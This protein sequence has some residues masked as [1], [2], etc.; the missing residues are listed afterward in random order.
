[1]SA[2]QANDVVQI[3]PQT[4]HT[5]DVDSVAYSPDGQRIV[6]GSDDGSIKVWET[7]NKQLVVTLLGFKDGEWIIYT[8]DNY[9]VASPNGDQ[10]VTFR[11]NNDSYGV[12]QYAAL[13]ERP[14]I[15][16]AALQGQDTQSLI[17]QTQQETGTEQLSISELIP[18]VVMIQY[19]RGYDDRFLE[20]ESQTLS[21]SIVKVFAKARDDKYGINRVEV[22]HNGNIVKT[23]VGSGKKSLDIVVPIYLSE[24]QI[25]NRIEL[26]AHSVK[27]VISNPDKI[28]LTYNEAM[29]KG[30]PLPK[31]GNHFFG[32]ERSW[33]VVIGIDQYPE[34]SGYGPLP[35]AVND[36]KKVGDVLVDYLNFSEQ[37]IIPLYGKQATKS[38]I[39]SLLGDQLSSELSENDA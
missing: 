37:R 6:S 38:A 13:Y 1:M 23:I 32:K 16:A 10:Y 21:D 27:T 30:W 2:V 4:G 8:P 26:V 22:L 9:Y 24:D 14:Q 28:F 17:A 34:E 15:I 25:D 31:I 18:P 29:M 5:D 19:L 39:V 20:P 7:Q 36:A 3:V 12:D 11:V 33:A 35:Y